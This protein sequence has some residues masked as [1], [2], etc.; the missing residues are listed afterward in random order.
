LLPAQAAKTIL[1]MDFESV[2]AHNQNQF[3]S[4]SPS[5]L[6]NMETE[7]DRHTSETC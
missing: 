2:L 4:G 6:P 3:F 1:A 7:N 5:R